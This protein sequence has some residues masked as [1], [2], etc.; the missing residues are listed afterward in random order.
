MDVL[1]IAAECMMSYCTAPGD[2]QAFSDFVNP[3]G[4]TFVVGPFGL[5][6]EHARTLKRFMVELRYPDGTVS[7][8]RLPGDPVS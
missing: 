5:C 3:D 6:E 7:K 2:V 4:E 8:P 1:P